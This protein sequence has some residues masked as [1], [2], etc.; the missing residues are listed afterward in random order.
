MQEALDNLQNQSIDVDAMRIRSFPFNLEVWEFIE[1][2]DLLFIV[3]QNRDGQM[4]TLLMA[5]GGIIPDKLVSI[6]C[7]DGQPIT[8]SFIT[9]KINAH[10]SGTPSVAAS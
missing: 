3:E 4:R 7:F 10:I 5:E 8:A 6:L 9:N 2:H 1:E